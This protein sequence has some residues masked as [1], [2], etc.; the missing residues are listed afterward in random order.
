MTIPT[1]I[2]AGLIIGK[3]T[4]NYSLAIASSVIMDFDHLQSYIKSGV[5]FKPKL[6]WNIV[7]SKV[8]PYGDQR[9]YLHNFV[10]FIVLSIIL[11]F[12]FGDMLTPLILGWFGHLF[13]DA[14][15]NSAY[16]PFYSYKWIN[17][18]GPILYASYQEFVFAIL[19]LVIY[20]VI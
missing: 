12:A 6:F 1:H 16:W 4:G 9:G 18:N 3:V 17:I 5:I 11:L 14:L 20:F 13:L 10:V 2:M 7:T 19:L 8:D 15:D